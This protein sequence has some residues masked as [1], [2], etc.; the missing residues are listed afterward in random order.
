MQVNTAKRSKLNGNFAMIMKMAIPIIIQGLVFQ[1]QAIV[2][3]A[4][5]G[6]LDT[7]YLSAVGVAQLPLFTSADALMAVCT[8]LTIIVSQKYGAGKLK[9]I[10][11]SVNASIAF[12]VL[13]SWLLFALWFAFP[14]VVFHLM[15]VDPSLLPYCHDYVSYL[16]II[17]II[18]GVDIS[19]Q[20]TLQG[21]GKT[22][23]IMYI[24]FIKVFLNIIL[25]WLLIFGKFGLPALHVKGAALATAISSLVGTLILIVYFITSKELSPNLH[26]REILH[27]RWNKYKE[28]ISLGLPTG[29]E[30][31]LWNIS[32]LILV[33]LLN[34]QGVTAVAIF[35]LTFAIE[36]IVYMVFNGI[37]RST[38][39]LV[40]HRIGAGDEKG[41]RDIMNSSIRYSVFFVIIF[42]IIFAIFPKPIL[43][44]FSNDKE[45]I[46]MAVFYLMLRAV[47]MFPKSL[48]VVVGSGIRAMGDV[49][50]MLCT[51]IFG[52]VFVVAFSYVLINYFEVGVIGIYL[53]LFFDEFLRATINTIRFYKGNVFRRVRV[54]MVAE[55]GEIP[56]QE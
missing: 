4:F 6:K 41:A 19:L 2:D 38:L 32:N 50:W 52:S 15:N 39:T 9:E 13:I 18:Y 1:L 54:G 24:G 28:I 7:N 53:T 43:S 16:S 49:K 48:N 12:N 51:Q 11:E 8:G 20:V 31:F 55:I 17:F 27:F 45:L 36:L 56:P 22:K 30:Y 5:L 14:D 34:K 23:Q 44:I 42:C 33:S 47:I 37:A 26:I 21:M 35:T 3:K 25:A 40:G 10:H 29:A 46:G